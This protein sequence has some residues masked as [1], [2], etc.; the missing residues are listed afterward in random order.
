MPTPP[1]VVPS[2]TIDIT[3]PANRLR[4]A[5][6]VSSAPLNALSSGAD[7]VYAAG[8]GSIVLSRSANQDVSAP[9]VGV[10]V[11][12]DGAYASE[13]SWWSP[14]DPTRLNLPAGLWYVSWRIAAVAPEAAQIFTAYQAV[15]VQLVGDNGT[16]PASSLF[17]EVSASLAS[18]ARFSRYSPSPTGPWLTLGQRETTFLT[19]GA[20]VQSDVWSGYALI[21][22]AATFE[23][24]VT[25]PFGAGKAYIPGSWTGSFSAG[26]VTDDFPAQFVATRI[27]PAP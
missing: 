3:L 11:A 26:S 1:C 10:A 22:D 27:A 2:S 5:A 14:L 18:T 6:R 19:G 12:W 20:T 25:V 15:G 8:D 9:L 17:S 23:V 21:P 13:S 7:G 24:Q 16:I 4:L